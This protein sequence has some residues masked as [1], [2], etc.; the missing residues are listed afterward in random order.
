MESRF[1]VRKHVV[2]VE[3]VGIY[4]ENSS[5]A[6]QQGGALF[7]DVRASPVPVSHFP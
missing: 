7:M 3:G 1:G 2:I 6:V 4:A 5:D